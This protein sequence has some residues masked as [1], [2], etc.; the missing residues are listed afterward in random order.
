MPN[1][2]RHL[3]AVSALTYEPGRTIRPDAVGQEIDGRT[4]SM[5]FVR[6]HRTVQS[7]Q[8]HGWEENDVHTS[9]AFIH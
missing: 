1:R 5:P 2:L 7:P 8:E 9:V 4:C 6:S 3:V